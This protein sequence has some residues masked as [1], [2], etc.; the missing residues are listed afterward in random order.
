MEYTDEEKHAN[1]VRMVEVIR[2]IRNGG[3]I[4]EDWMSDQIKFIKMC[5]DFYPNMSELNIDVTDRRWRSMAENSELLLSQ[6]IFEINETRSFSIPLYCSFCET[7][8][9][10]FESILSD[11]EIAMLMSQMTV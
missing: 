2:H 7:I 10:M 9:K 5:R 4:T 8:K 11:D 3:R 6:L 1:Y